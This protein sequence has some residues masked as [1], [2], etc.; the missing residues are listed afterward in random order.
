MGPSRPGR[1]GRFA[2]RFGCKR[3]FLSGVAVF[4]AA[5]TGICLAKPKPAEALTPKEPPAA[6]TGVETERTSSPTT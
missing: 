5:Y 3:V 4:T 6:T 2:D 1:L